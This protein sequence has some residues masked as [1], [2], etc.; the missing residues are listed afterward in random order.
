M[1]DK[2]ENI[3]S[4]EKNDV[5]KKEK[6]VIEEGGLYSKVN[7]SKRTANIIVIVCGILFIGVIVLGVL[8]G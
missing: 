6:H 8:L 5:S 2:D 3:K 4:E 7:I 1:E